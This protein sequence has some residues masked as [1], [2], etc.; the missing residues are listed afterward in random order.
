M[1]LPTPPRS[2]DEPT[3]YP[4]QGDNSWRR[5]DPRML[6]IRSVETLTSALPALIGLLFVG[7]AT[8]Q[9]AWWGIGGGVIAIAAGAAQWFT[10]RYR[11]TAEQVQVRRGL[12][13]SRMITVP[14][15]RV[16]T[17]DVT[18]PFLHRVLGL[19]RVKLGT[20]RSDRKDDGIKLDSLRTG[21][22]M[23]LREELLHKKARPAAAAQPGEADRHP[24]TLDRTNPERVLLSLPTSWVRYGPF[25]L[26]GLVTVGV[27]AGFAWR[28][29]E[30]AHVDPGR[31]GVTREIAAHWQ[32][33]PVAVAIIEALIAFIIVVAAASTTGYLLAFWRFRLTRHFSGTLHVTRGLITTRATTIE[34]RRLRGVEFSE[35]LLLR[36][37]RGAR[38]IAITTGLRVGWGSER[39]GSL[40]VPPAPRQT[41]LEV[42]AE[43]LGARSPLDARLTPHGFAAKRR[44]YTRALAACA[45]IGA[46]LITLA[47][48]S[49]WPHWSWLL[50]VLALPVGALLANDRAR[51][52]GHAMVD[53][54]LITQRGSIIRRRCML[55]RDGVIGWNMRSSFFQRR[56]GL[57]TLVATT[58]AGRQA[59]Q[60]QD[61][62]LGAALG[63]ADAALPGLLAPFL[64][65]APTAQ[66]SADGH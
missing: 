6:V 21:E 26:S 18:A 39:G 63:L 25:T 43:V 24:A 45:V 15:D 53:D 55:S 35:P 62:T 65:A 11:I 51:S 41:A 12:L 17:V 56:V 9:G 42:A 47:V 32:H 31:F 49:D 64:L 66:A 2:D 13:Q 60:V 61:V 33:T 1:S 27:V 54:R 4:A 20:G 48:S 44:R 38:C 7:R 59:Y 57:T 22:A 23:Q 37:V 28:L 14:L 30:E 5:L 3:E 10:T 19:A 52:L 50:G 34:E 16:R 29:I 8:G 36:A 58:A 46:A 40:L